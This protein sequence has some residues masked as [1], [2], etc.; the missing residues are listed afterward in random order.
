MALLLTERAER[1]KI[2]LELT[3]VLNLLLWLRT[4]FAIKI[5]P[6]LIDSV[7]I[8]E[9]AQSVVDEDSI[10]SQQF[11]GTVSQHSGCFGERAW[12]RT[13]GYRCIECKID[14]FRAV[15]QIR[16]S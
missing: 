5:S 14:A 10:R 7:G 2:N 1:E 12:R 15:D 11:P 13:G 4:I 16:P 6:L 9:Q 3:F 8:R